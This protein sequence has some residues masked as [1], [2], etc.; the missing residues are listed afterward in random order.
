MTYTPARRESR[1]PDAIRIG[2]AIPLQGPGGIFGPSCEAVAGLAQATINSATGVLG[3]PVEFEI[4]DAGAPVHHVAA[5]VHRLIEADRIEALT[6][7]H[8]SS[9]RQALAPITAGRIPYAYTSLYEGGESRE[10]LFC[11]GETPE[12]QIAPALR[13]LRSELGTRRWHI[14]GSDYIWPR[15]SSRAAR[16]FAAALGLEILSCTFTQFGTPSFAAALAIIERSLDGDGVLM[17]LVGQDAVEFNRE[18]A[19]RGLDGHLLRFAPLME[20]NMLLASGPRACRNMYVAAGYFRSL[21]TGDS[22]D[23]VGAYSRHHGMHAPPL[24]NQAESCYEGITLLTQLFTAAGSTALHDI[25]PVAGSLAYDSPRGR[26]E[27]V[28]GHVRQPIHLARADVADFDVL[29][30]L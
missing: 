10:G 17:F 8:I 21:A 30:R 24:N 20:E 4:I 9:V 6:G 18:F 23:L 14:V 26:V 5:Q 1:S 13:W 7:W 28:D 15:R 12:R 25:L 16:V 29:A 3:R 27:L 11:T 2:L 22:L 19:A